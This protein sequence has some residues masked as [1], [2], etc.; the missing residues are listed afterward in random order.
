MSELRPRTPWGPGTCLGSIGI[1]A[2]S[3][4]RLG[5]LVDREH[6]VL[7]EIER[8]A[9]VG[10]HQAVD[11]LDAVVDVAERAGLLAVSPDLDL[12]V[13]GQLGDGDLAAQGGRG[14]LAAAV[15]GA[16]RAEDVVEADGA[17]V[18]PVVLA[19]VLAEALDDELFPAVG[20]LGLGG[21]GVFLAQR[22]DVGVGLEV[23]G[24]DAG[25]RGVEVAARRR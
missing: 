10:A 15:P 14:L 6:P 20:V 21:I 5:E 25:R 24:V 19:V 2:M 11:A 7:A 13:A 23:L 22:L 12:G 16:E 8:L 3:A 9:V 1:S 4:M 18:E 17:G